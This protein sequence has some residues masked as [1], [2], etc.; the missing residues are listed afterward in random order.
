MLLRCPDPDGATRRGHPAQLIR[1]QIGKTLARVTKR[2][3]K[4]RRNRG[5]LCRNGLF[6]LE[7]SLRGNEGGAIC[8]GEVVNP[9][10]RSLYLGPTRSAAADVCCGVIRK[11]L[12]T[13]SEND[14]LLR[15]Y[16]IP[17]SLKVQASPFVF[18]G[19]GANDKECRSAFAVLPTCTVPLQVSTEHHAYLLPAAH[20]VS[21]SRCA[22]RGAP[23]RPSGGSLCSTRVC[24][25][26]GAIFC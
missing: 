10:A 3:Q 8:F 19:G 1:N 24:L 25:P 20:A 6:Y 9:L 2:R 15:G 13:I 5:H 23:R 16:S 22:L 26:Q 14:M 12:S 17:S 18:P 11:S 7:R 21:F 4:H